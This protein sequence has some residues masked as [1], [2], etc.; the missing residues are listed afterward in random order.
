MLGADD[1]VIIGLSGGADSVC[2]LF[3]LVSMR[4][5]YGLKLHAVHVHHGIRGAEADRDAEF[6]KA[7]CERLNVDYRLCRYDIPAIAREEKISEEEAGRNARYAE[8]RKASSECGGAKIAI[9]HN[10]N[11]QAET[12]LHNLARG[13]GIAGLAGIAP[14]NG[15]IIRPLLCVSRAEIEEYLAEIGASYCTDSTNLGD[16]YTR[17]RIRHDILPGL[18]DGVNAGA[19]RHVAES[20]FKLRKVKELLDEEAEREYKKLIIAGAG[21][22]ARQVLW[23]DD[24][25]ALCHEAIRGEV[26][27]RLF[28]ELTGH[29]KDF[30]DEHVDSL[31]ELY[32]RETGKK[33]NLPYGLVA[34][35]TYE[36]VRLYVTGTD[37]GTHGR[38]EAFANNNVSMKIV[39]TDI[40]QGGTRHIVSVSG[41]VITLSDRAIIKIPESGCIR[42]F[43]YDKMSTDL[44]LRHR[45]DGDRIALFSDGRGKSVKDYM[46]DKKIPRDLR[47]SLWVVAAG[48]DI[49][50]IY[51]DRTDAA[52]LIDE[53]TEH[54]IEVELYE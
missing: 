31:C 22:P 14:V 2:L 10:L 42:W 37:T 34:E 32:K 39:I 33:V 28:K 38:Y 35:K 18:A 51:G 25:F 4:E 6:T 11:D 30:T 12:V 17:N 7:L 54:I 43:D 3:L 53:Q 21:G 44:S 41:G 47:D 48:S 26:A 9:A 27:I 16:D 8:F 40:T 36:G 24:D 50:W 13:S 23:R 49:I 45:K 20:G 15:D 29:L 1:H 46:T 52:H 19:L 5:R